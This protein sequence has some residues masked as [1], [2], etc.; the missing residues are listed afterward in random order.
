MDFPRRH[1][2]PPRECSARDRAQLARKAGPVNSTARLLAVVLAILVLLATVAL[3]VDRQ[4][5]A[6]AAAQVAATSRR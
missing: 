6:S 4:S 1:M 3:E 2:P 5:R